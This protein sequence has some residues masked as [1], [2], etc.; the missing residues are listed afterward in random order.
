MDYY[1][2]IP[3]SSIVAL[4]LATALFLPRANA[5]DSAEELIKKGDV[6]YEK[7]QT[8]QA[9]EYYLPAEKLDPDNVSLLIKIAREYR[10]MMS[11]ATKNEEKVRLGKIATAYARRAA[12]LAPDDCEA[13]LA[14]A[15]SYG[16]VL[17][18]VGNKER[19]ESSRLIKNA[20][21]KAVALN[22]GNDLGWHVLGRWHL[23]VADISGVK[24]AVANIVYGKLPPATNEEAVKCFRKAIALNPKRL[25]HFIELGRTYAQMGKP[26]EA[27]KLIEKGLAM[28]ETEKDDPETKQKGRV[29]LEKLP[30]K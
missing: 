3:R 10:H 24:R 30:A 13:Q 17:P 23:T 21:Q 19:L 8:S 12:A 16:K 14:V 6:H 22:P 4:A 28:Q 11:D 18:F 9:L 7:L 20:A 1:T 27:R 25:M 15:I 26:A 5:A 29:I 2:M